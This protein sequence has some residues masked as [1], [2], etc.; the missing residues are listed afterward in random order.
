M[1]KLYLILAAICGCLFIA[2]LVWNEYRLVPFVPVA[3]V[4]YR[5]DH[6][7][8]YDKSMM[9]EELQNNICQELLE[10]G[11]YYEKHEDGVYIRNSLLK[12]MDLL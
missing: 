5:G 9:N 12:D 2:L 10:C 8:I 7:L 6:E 1:K 11:E 4:I 3:A